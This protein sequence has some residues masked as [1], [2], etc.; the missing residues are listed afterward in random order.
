MPGVHIDRD[1]VRAVGKRVQKIADA[2]P[3]GVSKAASAADEPLSANEGSGAATALSAHFGK[4]A[5]QYD[6]LTRQ[7]AGFGADVQSAV[8]TWDENE[9]ANAEVFDRYGKAL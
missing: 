2:M 9:G 1:S 6:L 4:W 7:V 5:E 8:S 3:K